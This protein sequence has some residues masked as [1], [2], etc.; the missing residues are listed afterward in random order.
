[1]NILPPEVIEKARMATLRSHYREFITVS[2]DLELATA[3]ARYEGERPARALRKCAKAILGRVANLKVRE[4]LVR[5]E[6]SGKAEDILDELL[7]MRDSLITKVAKE[8]A[9]MY[10][11]GDVTEYRRRRTLRTA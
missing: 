3:S 4:F 9:E 8:F 7:G 10:A 2:T 5:I 1:M 6:A 11:V